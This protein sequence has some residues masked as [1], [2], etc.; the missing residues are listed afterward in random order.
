MECKEGSEVTS[1]GRLP[2]NRLDR[3]LNTW[4]E[5]SLPRVFEGIAPMKPAAGTLNSKMCN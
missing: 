3:K 2:V 5:S 1:D 4:R